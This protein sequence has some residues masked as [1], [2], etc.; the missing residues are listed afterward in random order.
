MDL[1]IDKANL[2]SLISNKATSSLYPDCVK[3]MKKQ[4]NVFFNFPKSE[5]KT[6]TNL[7]TWFMTMSQGV[8]SS[9]SFTFDSNFPVK[10]LKSNSAKTFSS[11]QL[12][13][14]YLL[15]GE[16]VDKFKNS[17]AV[18]IGAVGEEIDVFNKLFFNQDDYLFD[19][20][21]K[22][23]GDDF[24]TWGDLKP[25]SL[26]L[27]DIIIIDPYV[28]SDLHSIKSNL[29]PYLKCLTDKTRSSVNIVIYTNRDSCVEYSELSSPIRAAVKAITGVKP[30]F[31][32]VTFIQKRGVPSN[33]AEHDRTILMNYERIYTGDTIN[34]FD[35]DGKVITNGREIHYSSLAKDENHRLATTLIEDIQANI[36]FLENNNPTCIQGDKK[37][38]YLNFDT[39]TPL[40]N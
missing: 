26:P 18:L 29:L 33:Q 12:S 21:W 15:D 39:P 32:L 10:P 27:S 11:E 35:T 24:K 6:N 20:R 28:V 17:G 31:T 5:L 22:I 40:P 16:G 38:G 13:S 23:G 36:K 4:L 9:N 1:Y 19:K 3:L 2:N 34:F 14:I 30:N 7:M 25:C 8:G 37:S